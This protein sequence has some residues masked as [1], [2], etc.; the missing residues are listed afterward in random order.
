MTTLSQYKKYYRTTDADVEA[1]HI[2]S[3]KIGYGADGRL[4]GNAY[5][6]A[7][8]HFDSPSNTVYEQTN[9]TW[10]FASGFTIVIRFNLETFLT[11]TWSNNYL[12]LNQSGSN[13]QASIL[14]YPSDSGGSANK[15][16]VFCQNGS[17]TNI[18]S[19]SSSVAL[20]GQGNILLLTSY[21]P[22]TGISH[23]YANDEDVASAGTSTIGTIATGSGTKRVGALSNVLRNCQGDIGFVGLHNT[24]IDLSIEANRRKFCNSDGSPVEQ[25]T[26]VWAN[27]G[28]GSQ[29]L[30]F[31]PHG[32]MENNLG[33]GGNYTKVGPIRV[34]DSGSV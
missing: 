13:N 7:M 2:K 28:F 32:D 27:S 23:M 34:G 6:P 4:V 26:T 9:I 11:A 25:D 22:A 16:N 5:T 31:N 24:Y 29:P 18:L 12:F 14:A 8:M 3:G 30:V 20:M 19:I 33:S 17:G 10:S 21:D 15:I 1:H